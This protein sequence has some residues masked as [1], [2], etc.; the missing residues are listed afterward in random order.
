MPFDRLTDERADVL[1]VHRRS[2]QIHCIDDANDRRIDRRGFLADGIAGR[3]SLE[4]DQHLL[5]D[6]RAD[7]VHRKQFRTARRVFERQRLHEQ[8]L[9]A[10]ELAI[11]LGGDERAG[12]TRA[13]IIGSRGRPL[14]DV[15]GIDDADDAGIGRH[16]GRIKRKAR[17][18]AAHEEHFFAYARAH[19]IGGDDDAA[20]RLARR[21][22]R[23]HEQQRHALERV[24][25]E[26]RTTVPTTRPSCIGSRSG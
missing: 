19:R 16:L 11:L 13:R 23:L 12:H 21:R 18:F 2:S 9:R 17:F 7:A 22:H 20:D 25:L 5:V 26:F 4:H 24:V 1:F 6:A 14:P 15:P 10:F 3:S 8:Q